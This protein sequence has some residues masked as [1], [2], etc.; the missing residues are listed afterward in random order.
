MREL[1]GRL[2]Y[3]GQIW[4]ETLCTCGIEYIK[5][6]KESKTSQNVI[7]KLKHG[8]YGLKD[9][10]RQFYESVRERLKT[11][12]KQYRLDPAVFFV[13]TNNRLQGMISCHVDDFL[14]VGDEVFDQMIEELRK[15]FSA[16]NV[17]EK[18]FKYLGF[19]VEQSEN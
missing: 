15:R 9:G 12:L 18:L 5:P 14:H 13:Q 16:G 11:G 1:T 4:Q 3:P 2:C 10:A 8:L 19:K 6:P 7:W 17:E